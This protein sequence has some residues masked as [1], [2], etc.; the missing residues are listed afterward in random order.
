MRLEI[1]R[2]SAFRN[3]WLGQAISQ[4]GDSLY[5]VIFMF[6][7]KKIT[8]SVAM[9]GYVNAM[10][11]LPFL[12]LGPLAGVVADRKDRRMLMS[13]SDV[14]SGTILLLFAVTLLV[15]GEPP[16]WALMATPFLLSSMRTFFLPAKNAAIPSLV[17]VARLTEANVLSATTQYMMPLLGLGL[18]ASALGVLYTV[19]PNAFF[20]LAVSL[21][22]VSFFGSAL[23]IRRLPAL[24]P[25]PKAEPTHA[26]RDFVEGLTYVRSRAE[27]VSLLSLSV[28]MSLMVSPFFVV[29][30]A[31]NEAWFGG[32][33]QT[34]AWF[35][36]SFFVG[37][38]LGS[39]ALGRRPVKHPGLAYVFG[40]LVV[41]VTVGAMAFSRTFP[42]FCLLNL[43]AGLG[44]PY[45]QIPIAVYLQ[46][47]VPDGF[48]GRVNSV[49][50][51][52]SMGV[53]PIGMALAG[54]LVEGVG[55]APAFLIMG[56]GMGAVALIGWSVRPFRDTRIPD[57]A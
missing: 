16:L 12:L 56:G 8:D 7:V 38:I 29:Y 18:S 32:K 47:T 33:P 11:A 52:L 25:P 51:T 24:V 41:G 17:P 54:V 6:M 21:N 37:M 49:L 1:L 55:L 26:W 34:L 2:I 36:F 39:I 23:F 19:A 30:V 40:T 28:A 43:L 5:F 27:L 45:A 48:M 3:L 15:S 9:V 20:V 44:L 57:S 42:T 10:A 31:S 46:S 14:A 35:E 22:A 13:A 4:V 53:M 50:S